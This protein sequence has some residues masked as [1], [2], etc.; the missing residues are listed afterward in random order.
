VS[1][2]AYISHSGKCIVCVQR[3]RDKVVA[4]EAYRSHTVNIPAVRDLAMRTIEALFKLGL[5]GPLN[6]QIFACDPPVLIEVNARLGSASV[7]SS[8]ACG[9][10]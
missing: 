1:V 5:R 10:A 2:D 3:I 4:G 7:F 9:G 8:V 6:V